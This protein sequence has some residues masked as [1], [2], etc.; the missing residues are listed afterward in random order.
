M[1]NRSRL[2]AVLGAIGLALAA[3][4]VAAVPAQA[5][6]A[7]SFG[8]TVITGIPKYDDPALQLVVPMATIDSPAL[9]AGSTAYVYSE[10]KAY[11][12]DRVNLVDNEIRCT[13]AGKSNVVMGENVLPSTGDPAHQNITIVTR[14]LVTATSPGVISCTLYLRT[15]STSSYVAKETVQGTV[16][17]ASYS[18][19]GDT[20]GVAMQKSL[21]AGNTVLGSTVVAPVLD[22]V[23]PAGY[24]KVDVVADAEFHWCAAKC[25]QQFSKA[26]FALSVTTSGGTACASAPVAQSDE[27][28]QLGVNHAAVPLY[29]TVTVKPGCTHLHAQVTSTYLSGN[30]GL[31]GGA[32]AGLT[33][34][35]GHSG[36]TPN[37]TSVMTHMFALPRTA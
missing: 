32:A 24:T 17:F 21:P 10:L 23:V 20:S 36:D 13:G 6:S 18:V 7:K 9:A 19:P 22:R 2:T 27:Y 3:I 35:T 28:V 30:V 1:S 29:T 14:F 5:V 31:V 4:V 25:P 34:N 11:A 16:R 26:R 12:A 33:D 15:S 37:H 8:P